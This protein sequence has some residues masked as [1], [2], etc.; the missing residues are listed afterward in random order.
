MAML[1]GRCVNVLYCATASEG[2]I[3]RV[4]AE[5]RFACPQC[6][7]A[8]V[9]PNTPLRRRATG[10]T[11][12]TIDRPNSIVIGGGGFMCGMLLGMILFNGGLQRLVASWRPSPTLTTAAQAA[13]AP[14]PKPAPAPQP[15]PAVDAPDPDPPAPRPAT[16]HNTHHTRHK[17]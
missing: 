10:R 5:G 15:A 13:P 1:P 7:K 16:H 14:V 17:T 2:E 6:S 12:R 8:L 11:G 4:P 9:P 3:V